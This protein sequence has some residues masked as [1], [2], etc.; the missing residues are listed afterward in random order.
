MVAGVRFG[1]SW[2]GFQVRGVSGGLGF[3]VCPRL[4]RVCSRLARRR[5]D[6]MFELQYIGALIIRA[7]PP[8][9]IAA[10]SL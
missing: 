9:K 4:A 10:L 3:H 5:S 2:L 7:G 8:K 1:G 6:W